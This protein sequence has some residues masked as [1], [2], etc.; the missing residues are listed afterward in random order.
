MNLAHWMRSRWTQLRNTVYGSRPP[1][2]PVL[3]EMFGGRDVTSGVSVTEKTAASWTALASGIRLCAETVAMLPIEVVERLEPRGRRARPDHPVAKVL[4]WPN[5]DMSCHEFIETMQTQVDLWGNAYAQIIFNGRGEPIELWPINPDRVTLERLQSG[6]VVYK[7]GAPDTIYGPS[8]HF[9]ILP[10]KEVLHIRGWSTYG[11]IGD[12]MTRTFQEAIG[13][14]LA[15]E[16]YGALFFGQGT[17]AGGILEHPGQLSAEARDRLI[18]QAKRQAGGISRAHRTLIVEEGMTWK[19][20][21]IDPEKAQFLGTRQFQVTEA[22]RILRIPPHMIYDLTRATFSNIEH[23]QTEFRLYSIQPRTSRWE[24]RLAMQLFGQK[25]WEKLQVKFN[26]GALL[27]GDTAA[28]TAAFTAGIQG[29]WFSPND[30]REYL[31]LNPRKGGDVY[32]T[33]PVG[34]APATPNQATPPAQNGGQDG[35]DEQSRHA[36]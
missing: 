10:A 36:A 34:G 16:L 14:G 23:Q 12:R 21:T 25:D 19:Q 30:V 9:E 22:A 28:Q 31:D 33:T 3:A 27:R 17:H 5:P 26:M 32:I 20:T 4:A 13:L 2:D 35:Q 29:G 24:K 15:T 8:M 1:R 18:E 11:L 7:I 6:K